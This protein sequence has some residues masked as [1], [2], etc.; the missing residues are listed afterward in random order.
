MKNDLASIQ[1]TALRCKEEGLPLTECA[2]RRLTQSGDIP[3]CRIGK[4]SL[5]YW[6]NVVEFVQSGN[7]HAAEQSQQQSGSIR[8]QG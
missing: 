6:A 2:L 7:N 8:R 3:A 1:D 4:K 5:L